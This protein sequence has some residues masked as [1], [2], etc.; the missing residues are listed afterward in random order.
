MMSLHAGRVARVRMATAGLFL[1]ALVAGATEPSEARRQLAAMNIEATPAR[2]VQYAAQ[3]DMTTTDLLLAAGIPAKA[4]EPVHHATALHA[5]AAQGHLVL[6]RRLLDSGAAVDA[7][8]D[9]GVTPLVN[10]AYFGRD[11]VVALLLERGANPDVHPK[12]APTPLIAA[13][14]SDQAAVVERLLRAGANPDQADYAGTTPVVAAERAGRTALAQKLRE[15][16][17]A[18]SGAGTTR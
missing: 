13:V 5:A 7:P 17:V 11:A 18:R 16:R 9:H 15:A 10:A 2:L 1:S 6:V 4:A 12:M 3:G 8:D 14:Q